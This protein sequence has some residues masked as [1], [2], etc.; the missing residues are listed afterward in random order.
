[1]FL[2]NSR[3]PL[4]L[5]SSHVG[6]KFN[7]K[8]KNRWELL[9]LANVQSHVADFPYQRSSLWLELIKLGDLL[10][11]WVRSNKI[12][13]VFRLT[14][15]FIK[16]ETLHESNIC[17]FYYNTKQNRFSDWFKLN[18]LEWIV[19]RKSGLLHGDIQSVLKLVIVANLFI[20][21]HTSVINDDFIWLR[22][23]NLIPF[24]NS[25][26]TENETFSI[27]KIFKKNFIRYLGSINS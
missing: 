16:I 8:I 10:R 2:L 12:F 21:E 6:S 4:I 26:W 25:F 19:K 15:I 3:I 13:L 5:S 14:L 1:M 27:V 22:T 7:P 9:F 20:I 24:Q 23:I 11:L 18:G 17:R